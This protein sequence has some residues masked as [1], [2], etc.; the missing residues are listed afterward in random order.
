[1]PGLSALIGLTGVHLA[2]FVGMGLLS[3]VR[4]EPPP[5]SWLFLVTFLAVATAQGV[6]SSLPGTFA[7][8]SILGFVW[9]GAVMLRGSSV[10]LSPLPTRWPGCWPLASWPIRSRRPLSRPERRPG[11][12]AQRRVAD[13]VRARDATRAG[14]LRQAWVDVRVRA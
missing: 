4:R 10:R 14:R 6:A 1:M 9:V 5:G 11:P 8:L 13:R 2:L 12:A 7:T 3:F